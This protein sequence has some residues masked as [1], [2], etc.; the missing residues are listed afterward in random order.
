[1]GDHRGWSARRVTLGVD[2]CGSAQQDES[3]TSP[4]A[5]RPRG[6]GCRGRM[7]SC[8]GNQQ[9]NILSEH[10]SVSSLRS[11]EWV[12]SP[13][14]LPRKTRFPPLRVLVTVKHRVNHDSVPHVLVNN[15]E[16]KP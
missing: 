7:A 6:G 8:A 15:F 13:V 12:S 3:A 2:K 14:L 1:M 16:R 11:F 10:Q 5:M 4:S 9:G